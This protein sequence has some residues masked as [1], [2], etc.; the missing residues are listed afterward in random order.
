[1]R[2]HHVLLTLTLAVSGCSEPPEPGLD[3]AVIEKPSIPLTSPAYPDIA[4]LL[5]MLA[6]GDSTSVAIVTDALSKSDRFA[7]LNIFISLDSEG[8][9][10]RAIE[11][12]QNRAAGKVLGPLHGIPLVVKD[13]I[14]VADMPN[15][16]G[17][18]ALKSFVP[19][20]SNEV[21][22]RLEAA[23][24][25]ILGKTNMH[26][27][28]FGITSDNAGFGTVRNPYN[29]NLIPGGSS[30]GTAVAVSTGIV[31]AGLGTDTGGSVRIPPALTGIVGFR[32]SMGR[33]PSEAVTPISTTRD[34]IGLLSRTVADLVVLDSVIVPGT[35]TVKAV[36]PNEIRLGLPRAYF[37]R[38]V[39]TEVATVTEA[40][41]DQLKKAGIQ[42]IE[43]D[44]PDIDTLMANSAFPIA[45]YEVLRDLTIYLEEFDTGVSFA[46]LTTSAAS[47]DVQGVLGL[48]SGEG[49]V[50]DEIY[51]AAMDARQRLRKNFQEYFVGQQLDAI[52]FPTTILPARPIQGSHES[53]E[54]NGEQVPTL[55]TYIHN[56]DPASI[57]ALPGISLPVGLTASGLPVGME[58]DG[59]EQSDRRLLGIAKT[60]ETIIGFSARPPQ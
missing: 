50:N 6:D 14:H 60:L 7:S 39:D 46:D 9:R 36:P 10:N 13:N 5:T 25:I 2:V 34:T 3:L 30:G 27:L 56:T 42:L 18:P 57:A 11:L 53:V 40:V 17:T 29:D 58:I 43:A 59:P 31:A 44:I 4:S 33:Y 21:V 15:T 51:A 52:I 38:N 54:L 1:M 47:P 16:A 20:R 26:E 28:A 8:A 41:L 22:E 12:D 32:P 24:A 19:T 45:F 55:P 35:Q 23:G 49:R 48:V 37:Y